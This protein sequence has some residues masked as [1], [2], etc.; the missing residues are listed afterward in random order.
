M[1]W[2][3]QVDIIENVTIFSTPIWKGKLQKK[4]GETFEPGD[5]RIMERTPAAMI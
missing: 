3:H 4:R 5:V 1:G 2:S